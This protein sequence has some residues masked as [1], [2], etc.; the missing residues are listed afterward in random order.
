MNTD[1]RRLLIKTGSKTL[2]N[3]LQL[4]LSAINFN[5]TRDE[6]RFA[7][8][9]TILYHEG[10]KHSCL[11]CP[12]DIH[13]HFRLSPANADFK[14]RSEFLTRTSRNQKGFNHDPQSAKGRRSRTL[15]VLRKGTQRKTL[16]NLY[17][18]NSCTKNKNFTCKILRSL[19]KA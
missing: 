5:Q 9:N 11:P 19:E 3:P 18:E 16:S 8:I 4:C 2:L 6:Q 14:S 17:D 13:L 15:C 10:T 1:K 12:A 7:L